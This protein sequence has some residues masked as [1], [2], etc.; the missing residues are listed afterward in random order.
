MRASDPYLW[1][2]E[3]PAPVTVAERTLTPLEFR[4]QYAIA[5]EAEISLDRFKLETYRDE[6]L[7]RTVAEI[8]LKV[9]HDDKTVDVGVYE[10]RPE[11]WYQHLRQRHWPKWVL[12]RRPV[13]LRRTVRTVTVPL[14]ELW[15]DV[16]PTP[17]RRVTQVAWPEYRAACRT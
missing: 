9:L 6:M 8:S 7:R 2:A 16:S 3:E 1:S 11:S 14:R 15:P 5:D 10:T 4:G 17:G 12:K 13:R